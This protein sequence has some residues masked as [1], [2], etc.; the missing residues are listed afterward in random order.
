MKHIIGW[1]VRGGDH[2][3][4]ALARQDASIGDLE[5][6]VEHLGQVAAEVQLLAAPAAQLPDQLRDV[7]DDLGDRIA[8]INARLEV[9]EQRL[10][11][12]DDAVGRLVDSAAPVADD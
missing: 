1:I 4:A 7:V 9:L 2:T 11:D 5:H 12:V 10:G 8:A 3:R 6:K